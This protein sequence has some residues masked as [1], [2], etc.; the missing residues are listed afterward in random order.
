[1]KAESLTIIRFAAETKQTLGAGVMLSAQL[2]N[3][4][5]FKTVELPWKDNEKYVSCIPPGTYTAIKHISPKFG[6][7]LWIQN[8]PGR[9][10]ILIHPA[11]YWHDLLGCIAPGEDHKHID[12]DGSLDVNKSRLMMEQILAFVEVKIIVEILDRTNNAQT[13]P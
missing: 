9:S 2:D 8:V 11:N 12:A 7:C 13:N 10:E 6:P 5:E 4:L 3:L 1:M